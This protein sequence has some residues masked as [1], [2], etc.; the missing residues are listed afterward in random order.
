MIAQKP[1][2]T[3]H[4]GRQVVLGRR[5][6]SPRVLGPRRALA[7]RLLTSLPAPASARDWIAAAERQAGGGDLGVMLNDQ[8]GDCTIAAVGHAAQ[9]WTANHGPMVTPTDGQILNGYETVDGYR[10][11]DPSTDNG[12][13]EEAVLA[14]WQD[15]GVAGSKL[16][17]W[18]PVNPQNIDHMRKVIERY[19]VA[20][21]GVALPKTAQDQA[22]WTL[23]IGGG[24]DAEAGSWGGHAVVLGAYDQQSFDC[25]T[26]GHRQKMSIDWLLAYCDEAYAP[27]CGGLW[28]GAGGMSPVGDTAQQL[29]ADFDAV[30]A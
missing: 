10:P 25:V 20:Y 9:I 12:G 3:S 7:A 28:C 24:P 18:V 29:R 5:H 23:A 13:V 11:G 16:D 21:V 14:A 2:I 6:V 1:I 26:W 27:L 15:P 17:G 30:A 8:L 4:L 19:G 22:V